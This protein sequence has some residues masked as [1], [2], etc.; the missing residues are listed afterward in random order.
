MIQVYFDIDTNG[1]KDWFFTGYNIKTHISIQDED[2]GWLGHCWATVAT[3]TTSSKSIRNVR[4]SNPT[5]F[6]VMMYGGAVLGGLMIAG[7]LI[8]IANR[9]K[10]KELAS[11]SLLYDQFPQPDEIE[12]A[13]SFFAEWRR[14]RTIWSNANGTPEEQG[15][16]NNN[17]HFS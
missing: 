11:Q 17:G 2:G 4:L 12:R 8:C 16:G 3:S 5:A 6:D 1:Y 9:N 14:K 10:E 13:R 7:M 15:G